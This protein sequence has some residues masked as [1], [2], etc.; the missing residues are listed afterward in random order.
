MAWKYSGVDKVRYHRTF[1]S[2]T[3]ILESWLIFNSLM[4]RK[5]GTQFIKHTPRVKVMFWCVGNI[6]QRLSPIGISLGS[7]IR[8]PSLEKVISTVKLAMKKTE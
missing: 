5:K 8:H 2:E 3:Y 7:A 6:L 1:K 4:A